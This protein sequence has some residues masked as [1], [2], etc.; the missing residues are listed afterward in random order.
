MTGTLAR[1]FRYPIKSVGAEELGGVTLAAG[2]S[3]PLDREWAVLNARAKV[4]RT[5]DG[6]ASAWGPKANFLTGR[7]GPALM[8][9]TAVTGPEGRL[10]LSHPD[11]APLDLDP[12][13]EEEQARLLAWLAPIWP[14]EAPAPVALVRAPGQPLSDQS[15]PLVA[16]IGSASLADLSARA[17]QPL[18]PRRFRANLWVEGWEPFAEFDLIGR[19]LRIGA[20]ILTVEERVG[21]CRA[22]DANPETGQRDIDMLRLL[23]AG[24]GHTDLGIFCS[25]TEGG[26]IARGDRVEIL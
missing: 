2:R 7:A 1:I 20:T 25:V 8:A 26:T 16:L 11:L 23:E 18:S 3:L 21:R 14:A 24:Y 9:V 22:T 6:R 19:R 4:T 17:G 10:T 12:A 15:R 5:A 13:A